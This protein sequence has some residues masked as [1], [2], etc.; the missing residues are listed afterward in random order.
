MGIARVPLP[1]RV[2]RLCQ[3]RSIPERPGFSSVHPSEADRQPRHNV[4][5]DRRTSS[6]T[7]KIILVNAAS[8]F[9]L[10]T[11]IRVV[12]NRLPY[13]LLDQ[14]CSSLDVKSVASLCLASKELHIVFQPHIL[15]AHRA[16]DRAYKWSVVHGSLPLFRQVASRGKYTNISATCL[17]AK[18]GQIEIIKELL[19]NQEV[20][21][22]VISGKGA[23]NDN[24]GHPLAAAVRASHLEVVRLF[25]DLP[26]ID[27]DQI[28]LQMRKTPLVRASRHADGPKWLNMLIDCG[29]DL[30]IAQPEKPLILGEAIRHGTWATI[31]RLKEAGMTEGIDLDVWRG[32]ATWI[33]N[34]AEHRALRRLFL[35][36]PLE[37]FDDP[38]QLN[39]ALR[40]D[41]NLVLR[42]L[43]Q[44]PDLSD[45]RYGTALQTAVNKN[46]AHKAVVEVCQMLV[47]CGVKFGLAPNRPDKVFFYAADND[48]AVPLLEI[49]IKASPNSPPSMALSWTRTRE[50]A[51]L[52][53]SH[54]ADPKA[55]HA[56][57]RT[58]LL[59]LLTRMDIRCQCLRK[60]IE[61][62][63]EI[64]RLLLDEGAD[65]SAV[66]SR[67]SNALP[68]VM[69]NAGADRELMQLLL[70]R[71]AKIA[72]TGDE[73][74]TE[75]WHVLPMVVSVPITQRLEF[76][77]WLLDEGALIDG[78]DN[79]HSTALVRAAAVADPR[80]IS[81]LLERGASL[82]QADEANP[83]LI[84]RVANGNYQ[85]HPCWTQSDLNRSF[86]ECTKILLDA[87]AK[88]KMDC[89]LGSQYW[90]GAVN[91]Q[92]LQMYLDKGLS[93]NEILQWS[94]CARPM[95]RDDWDQGSGTLLHYA[96]E[97]HDMDMVR[98]LLD[99]GAEP[100]AKDVNGETPWQR[101]VQYWGTWKEPVF[102][103]PSTLLEELRKTAVYVQDDEALATDS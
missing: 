91:V 49:L 18:H 88:T 86:I 71:G 6:V 97:K 22:A 103:K 80:L 73:D 11:D 83:S 38:R 13:E 68:L 15:R 63:R 61:E 26:G 76:A 94:R 72:P 40:L 9:T 33:S 8:F 99:A 10:T 30:T 43:A 52:L 19:L 56:D 53:I 37:I 41:L 64:V 45:Y 96:V 21:D 79:F 100:H 85:K 98:F 60:D 32:Y 31:M 87:G 92:H 27:L 1:L 2:R 57:G 5:N 69:A 39:D 95:P 34:Q 84:H 12:M 90:P 17:A 3:R 67:G 59:V 7:S 29:V 48:L 47:D 102:D 101:A 54:G 93:P 65:A 89:S 50:A 70:D 4:N 74:S 62:K 55:R 81:F 58:P 16:L 42:F 77:Q 66:D 24:W 75:F 20:Y 51:R 44:K 36:A 35:V 23:Q 78:T 28:N 14:V 46:R 82:K 25:L